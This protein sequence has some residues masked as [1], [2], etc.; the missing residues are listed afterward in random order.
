MGCITW[1]PMPS[2]FELSLANGRH[3]GD[4]R[5]GRGRGQGICSSC[6]LPCFGMCGRMTSEIAP[7]EAHV[8]AL[9]PCCNF[10]RL[11]ELGLKIHS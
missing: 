2:S 7:G 10:L 5:M 8:L 3:V 6:S 9:V 4:G 11:T 1:A